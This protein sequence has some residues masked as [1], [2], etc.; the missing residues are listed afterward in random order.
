MLSNSTKDIENS[1]P[2]P[3]AA[4]PR[5]V[6]VAAGVEG[7]RTGC[8]RVELA[9]EHRFEVRGGRRTV[10]RGKS[11]PGRPE[12]ETVVERSRRSQTDQT[13]LTGDHRGNRGFKRPLVRLLC[14]LANAF[15]VSSC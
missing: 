3:A 5:L 7:V 8:R 15:G 10:G 9:G 13:F 11:G 4:S 12:V 2:T 1:N 6:G 14:L